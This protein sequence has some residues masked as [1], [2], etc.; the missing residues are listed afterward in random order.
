MQQIESH[1][2]IVAQAEQSS[3]DRRILWI[4]YIHVVK[5]TMERQTLKD[6]VSKVL[7]AWYI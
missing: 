7:Q 5:S 2:V 6:Y 4:N 3:M 1:H